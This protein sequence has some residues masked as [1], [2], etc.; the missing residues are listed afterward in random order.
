MTQKLIGFK[1]THELFYGRY[2]GRAIAAVVWYY[3][4]D[5]WQKSLGLLRREAA[6]LN[7]WKI[8]ALGTLPAGVIGLAF[9]KVSSAISVP[10]VIAL[11]LIIGGVILWLVDN[12]PVHSK[13][14]PVTLDSITTKQALLIGLGQ[15]VAMIPGVS[16]SGATIVSGLAVKL[17]RPT[18]TAFSFYLSIPVLVLAS[19]Y[20]LAKYSSDVPTISGGWVG[21]IIGLVAA[22]FTALLA[23]SWLIRYIAHHNF[24]PFA[25]YRIALGAILLLALSVGWI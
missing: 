23:V 3:R 9:D 16:R 5:L 18:A 11:A 6:A 14:D 22:F 10:V 12:K 15:C 13:D 4:H 2:T 8:L 25:V 17:N 21:I 19:A 1:D 20:K 7:F 24:K